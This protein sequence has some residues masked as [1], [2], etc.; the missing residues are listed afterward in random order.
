MLNEL[1]QLAA[2]TTVTPPSWALGILTI[3][4]LIA[5]GLGLWKGF[6]D[7]GNARQ[8]GKATVKDSAIGGYESL[9]ERLTAENVRMLERVDNLEKAAALLLKR[10]RKL[11]DILHEHGI[12]IPDDTE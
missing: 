11:E 5:G 6:I 3:I 2:D 12:E 9:N 4:S 1:A 10:V 8:S 7:T